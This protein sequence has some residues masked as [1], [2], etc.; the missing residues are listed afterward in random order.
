MLSL[1]LEALSFLRALRRHSHMQAYV[2]VPSDLLPGFTPICRE[3]LLGAHLVTE[4]NEGTFS[5]TR[6]G[7]LTDPATVPVKFGTHDYGNLTARWIREH[8]HELV[9]SITKTLTRKYKRSVNAGII[10]DH[11]QHFLMTMIRRDTLH[12]RICRRETIY[13]SQVRSWCVNNVNSQIRDSAREPV[14]RL[15][16]GAKTAK[17]RAAEEARG[18]PANMVEVTQSTIGN[19]DD[20]EGP[21]L[22]PSERLKADCLG[23]V[24]ELLD[25]H[26]VENFDDKLELWEECVLRDSPVEEVAERHGLSAWMATR[27]IRQ[28]KKV[29]RE[30]RDEFSAAMLG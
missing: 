20:E 3:E 26:D 13:I 8:H 9:P 21:E 22:I 23:L 25:A 2:E 17:E 6:L 27:H 30:N 24:R 16:L 19:F 10:E 18:L 5:L 28:V 1:S 15:F 11:I 14:M 4:G 7:L 12:D 29:L